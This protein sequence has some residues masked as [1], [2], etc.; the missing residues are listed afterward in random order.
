MNKIDFVIL[1]VDENDPKWKAE[2]KKWSDELNVS[3]KE[4]IDSSD[5]RFRD[6]GLLRYWF[7]GVEKFAPWVNKI[8]FVTYGHLPDWLDTSH[9]KLHVVKHSDF[10]PKEILPVF[11]VNPIELLLHKIEG[12]AED[13]VYFN[14]DTL[15]LRPVS[16]T[17]FFK[18]GVP[19]NTMSLHPVLL[20]YPVGM[21]GIVSNDVRLINKHFDYKESVRKN[22][23]KYFSLKQGKYLVKTLPM[24]IYKEFPGFANFHMP[25]SFT[26][27][28]LKAVWEVEGN[29]LK[30]TLN[31]KFR[32]YE[33]DYS[34]WLFNYWQFANGDFVQRN[35][36]FGINTNV[37]NSKITKLILKRKAKCINIGDSDA[38]KD[39]E[40]VKSEITKALEKVLS[41]K[42]SYEK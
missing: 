10:M 8:H 41:K 3:S 1:W 6:W 37:A 33:N 18:D 12:L 40:K 14:D 24:L 27:T 20:T 32:D 19:V 26:K 36:R 34:Q 35:V 23:P 11:N 29:E 42:S 15:L 39:F 30:T 25:N 22:L 21:S 38:V 16:K 13:F 9:P 5:T 2:R 17:D 7:R 31:H 28:T 4:N